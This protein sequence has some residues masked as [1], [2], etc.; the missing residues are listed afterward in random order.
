MDKKTKML[1]CAAAAQ[2]FINMIA[3]V[4]Q[5]RKRKRRETMKPCHFNVDVCCRFSLY[6]IIRLPSVL[7][8]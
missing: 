2:W 8:I 4:V 1:I 3:L 7:L 5:S 6:N